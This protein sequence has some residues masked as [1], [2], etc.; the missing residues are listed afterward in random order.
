MSSMLTIALAVVLILSAFVIY[1]AQRDREI[2]ARFP[3]TGK[4]TPLPGGIIHWTAQ[5]SGPNV[6]L[7]HGLAGNKHNFSDLEKSLSKHFTVYSLDRPGSGH[8]HRHFSTD[9][10]FSS[11]A[12]MIA[13][14]MEAENINSAIFVGHSMGGAI[15][16]NLAINWPEKVDALALICPLTAPLSIKPSRIVQWYLRS[17]S[18]RFAI[19]KSFSPI[20]QRKIGRKQVNAIFKPEPPSAEFAYRY[21]GALSML[22]S[23]FL[24]ASNDLSHAQRSLHEQIARYS[25]IICPVTVLFGEGDRILPYQPHTDMIKHSIPHAQIEVMENRGHML[26]VTAVEACVNVIEAISTKVKKI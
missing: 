11:Q 9:P 13:S 26:P 12:N 18:L 5:G 6:V 21:G 24:A 8:S 22:S 10:S 20:I 3:A 1:T 16:L 2:K 23:A 14:W 7:V 4:M 25:E 17:R 15:S 19:A